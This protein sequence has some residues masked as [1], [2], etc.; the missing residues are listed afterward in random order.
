MSYSAGEALILTK[1]QAITG[2][3]WTTSN[4][5]RGKWNL[6]NSGASD[7]YAILRSGAGENVFTT[8]SMS[9]RNYVTVIEVWQSYQDDG[10]SYENIQAYAEGILDQFDASRKIGDTTGD[11]QDSRCSRWDEVEVRWTRGGGPRW[12]RQNFYIEWKEDN[13]VTFS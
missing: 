10:T 7:H 6:L 4:S 3:V 8:F 11:V 5:G 12:L 13:N 2:S 1:L 9:Q